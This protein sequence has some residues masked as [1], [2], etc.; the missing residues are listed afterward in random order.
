MAKDNFFYYNEL[1]F[2]INKDKKT[3]TCVLGVCEEEIYYWSKTLKGDLVIPSIAIDDNNGKKYLVTEIGNE[4]FWNCK[5]LTSVLIPPKVTKIGDSAF[6]GCYGLRSIIV[7]NDNPKYDSRENCNAII[8]T[9]SDTLIAGCNNTNIPSSIKNIADGAFYNC[10]GL[11]YVNIPKSVESIGS[12]AFEG[13]SGLT[14]IKVEEG[15]NKYDSRSDC[16]AIIETET[17]TLIKGCNNTVIPSSITKIEDCAFE[18]CSGLESVIMPD[19]VTIIG[20]EAFAGCTCLT[21]VKISNSL[22]II[23]ERAFCDCE[24]L[25]EITIPD[26]VTEIYDCAFSGCTKLKTIN[27]GNSVND[28]CKDAFRNTAWL[29]NQPDGMVYAGKVAYLYKGDMVDEPFVIKEGCKAISDVAFRGCKALKSITIPDSVT[30]IGAEAFCGCTNL[31]SLT[32]SN[33]VKRVCYHAFKGCT[34]LVSL[35]I[36]NLETGLFL[37]AF[38]GC[39]SL[40]SIFCKMTNPTL[41]FDLPNDETILYIPQGS[42]ETYKA[43][44]FDESK[45]VEVTDEEMERKIAELKEAES[46]EQNIH[47]A[48]RS[49]Q[50]IF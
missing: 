27:V 49:N 14:S 50:H 15:N 43:I 40:Q 21:E 10:S 7:D 30:S 12:H 26:S 46:T 9:E 17:N 28:I 35:T 41:H 22:T 39:D 32:L 47:S 20:I 2:I 36:P 44:G 8:E 31:T 33:S 3:V 16:N 5:G 25:T 42:L 19:S 13:C 18:G 34:K 29:N 38:S 6:R 23:E 24:N 11:T 37:D 45:L 48:Y 4:A 1:S